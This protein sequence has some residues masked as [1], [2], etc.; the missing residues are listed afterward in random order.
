MVLFA[1]V[2]RSASGNE[3]TFYQITHTQ[4]GIK[5]TFSALPSFLEKRPAFC[6][7]SESEVESLLLKAAVAEAARVHS[8]ILGPR[9]RT[10]LPR[11]HPQRPFEVVS[12]LTVDASRTILDSGRWAVIFGDGTMV[13]PQKKKMTPAEIE[14]FR[15]RTGQSLP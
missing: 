6:S 5:E 2:S 15:K 12:Y 10:V 8:L 1:C 14:S 11:G 9:N 3:V 13:L 7:L 4:K